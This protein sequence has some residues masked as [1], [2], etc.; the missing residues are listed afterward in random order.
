[1]DRKTRVEKQMK[2]IRAF[3]IKEKAANNKIA[4]MRRELDKIT[5]KVKPIRNLPHVPGMLVSMEIVD[6]VEVDQD[7]QYEYKDWT[8]LAKVVEKSEGAHPRLQI[9]DVSKTPY[10][11][12]LVFKVKEN[13]L[14]KA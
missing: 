12:V 6:S 11:N 7:I 3:R 2:K 4:K 10:E 8:R 9:L 5:A 1:M 14:Y 13:R